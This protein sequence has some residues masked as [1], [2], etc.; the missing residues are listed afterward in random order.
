MDRNGRG[1][2]CRGVVGPVGH[3]S[4]VVPGRLP[5]R[6][7]EWPERSGLRAVVARRVRPPLRR[8]QRR[9]ADPRRTRTMGRLEADVGTG[10][11]SDRLP[12][13]SERRWRHGPGDLGGSISTAVVN[14]GSPRGFGAIYGVGPVWSPTEDLI[15]YQRMKHAGTEAHD[16]VLVAP[17][18]GSEVFLPDLHLPGD[19]ASVSQRPDSVTWSPDGKELLYSAWVNGRRGRALI[20]RPL[21]PGS[22][23]VVAPRGHRPPRPE[24]FLGKARG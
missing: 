22:E 17:D 20:S 5:A 10:R 13:R 9:H 3:R 4:R 24:P 23:P 8:R 14:N 7:R 6:D 19:H 15:V 2:P 21:E 12:A 11:R 1:R 16:V 18:G